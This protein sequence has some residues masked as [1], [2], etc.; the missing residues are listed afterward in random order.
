MSHVRGAM[1][2]GMTNARQTGAPLYVCISEGGMSSDT[3]RMLR[4]NGF[5]FH[6]VRGVDDEPSADTIEFVY[7]SPV[8]KRW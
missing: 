4:E 1:I 6:H 7:Y 2:K 3:L 8:K 5:K